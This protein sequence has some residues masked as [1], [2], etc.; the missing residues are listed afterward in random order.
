MP[1]A[2]KPD[3]GNAMFSAD[4]GVR[5][6]SGRARFFAKLRQRLNYP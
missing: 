2:A 3:M 5:T 1:S 4:R 6:N